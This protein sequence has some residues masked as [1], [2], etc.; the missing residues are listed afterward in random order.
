[1]GS[2]AGVGG[3]PGEGAEYECEEDLDGA[4]PGDLR[5][6]EGQGGGVVGLVDAE[7][8]G[9]APCERVDEVGGEDLEIGL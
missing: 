2:V 6:G 3:A 9:V 5:G 4:D 8:G 1:V 7:G